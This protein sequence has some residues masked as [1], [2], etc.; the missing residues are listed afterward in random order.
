[1]SMKIEISRRSTL[2]FLSVAPAIVASAIEPSSAEP[3]KAGAEPDS[4][5]ATLSWNYPT[6]RTDGG[7]L[8]PYSGVHLKIST[9]QNMADP[10][11]DIKLPDHVTSF[12]LAVAP[13]GAYYWQ[14][15][16]F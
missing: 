5:T 4:L 16:P 8:A 1:M 14:L 11:V 10:I 15:W 6:Q 13:E 3:L 9:H 7:G 12:R 2:K